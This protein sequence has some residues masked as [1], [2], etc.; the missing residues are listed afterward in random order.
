MARGVGQGAVAHFR[1]ALRHGCNE[2]QDH[3]RMPTQRRESK[4]RGDLANGKVDG[5]HAP[6]GGSGHTGDDG[7]CAL[8]EA[9]AFQQAND[10]KQEPYDGH[11]STFDERLP[12]RRHHFHGAESTCEPGCEACDSDDEQRI[13]PQREAD[14]DDQDAD[15]C[16]HARPVGAT[17]QYPGADPGMEGARGQRSASILL[18]GCK[19]RSVDS[20]MPTRVRPSC[21]TTA[22]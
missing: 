6:R 8:L 9:G 7:A 12:E 10:G 16:E 5:Q 22:S 15:Q 3:L 4:R 20:A 17:A 19:S 1:C 13:H 2:R 11:I 21:N 14:N 18:G